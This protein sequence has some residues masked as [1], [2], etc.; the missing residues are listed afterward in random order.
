MPKRTHRHHDVLESAREG[1]KPARIVRTV[2]Q[3]NVDAYVVGVTRE[4]CLVC[5]VSNHILFD[6]FQVLRLED[7]STVESP[8]PHAGF[9]ERALRLRGQNHPQKPRIDLGSLRSVLTSASR[10][11]PLITI[12]REIVDPEVCHVGVVERISDETVKLKEIDPDAK[13]VEDRATYAMR[14]I[15][16]VDFGGL[17]EDALSLVAGAG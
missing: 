12:H 10:A 8:G 17:Y 15:T 11:F 13:W 14:E 7:I 3:G 2:E 1:G 5:V 16:R 6:G 4:L 9:L